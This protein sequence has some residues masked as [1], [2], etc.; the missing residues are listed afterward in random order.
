MNIAVEGT[1]NHTLNR[2]SLMK[3]PGLIACF[4]VGQ[5]TQAPLRHATNISGADRS[6]VKSNICNTRTA[7]HQWQV[8][9]THTHTIARIASKEEKTTCCYHSGVAGPVRA[10]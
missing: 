4:C 8:V 7:L 5:Q 10:R 1:E 2:A 6:N 9:P 3:A